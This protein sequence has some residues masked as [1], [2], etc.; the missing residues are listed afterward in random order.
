MFKAISIINKNNFYKGYNFLIY[1]LQKIPLLGKIIPNKAFKIS[2]FDSFINIISLIFNILYKLLT[3]TIFYVVMI[4]FIITETFNNFLVDA[5]KISESS[6]INSSSLYLYILV[7]VSLIGIMVYQVYFYENTLETYIYVKQMKLEAK[8]YYLG[9]FFYNSFIFIITFT[10]VN[11][12]ILKYFG[13]NFTIMEILSFIVFAY[14][15]R[16]LIAWIFLE[17]R[18]LD[19][20]KRN[21]LSYINWGLMAILVV[22]MILYVIFSK[23]IIDFRFLFNIKYLFIGL[24]IFGLSIVFLLRN[25][26][27]ELVSYNTLNLAELKSVDVKNINEKAYKMDEKKLEKGQADFSKYSGIEY[28][29]KIFFYRTSHIL[30]MKK[31][32][33]IAIRLIVFIA[34]IVASFVTKDQ[35]SAEDSKFMTNYLHIVLFCASYFIFSGDFFIRYCFMNMDLSMMKNNFYRDKEILL[36]SI[37]IRAIELLKYFIIPFL[38]YLVMTILLSY[39]FGLSIMLTLRNVCFAI[40]GL[41]VF[42]FHYLFAYYIIQP[43]TQGME[44]KNPLYTLLTYVIYMGG[45]ISI[46]SGVDTKILT[47]IFA[48]FSVVY[49]I[50]GYFGVIKLAPKRFKIK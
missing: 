37:K 12:F 9:S 16:F 26:S 13:Y 5:I 36:K 27:I 47:I 48:A 40:M 15:F 25:K 33:M 4:Y 2:G 28:I 38:A 19:K 10:P 44:V 30:K 49:M 45:Y 21:I 31:I 3:K 22:G 42:T 43:F 46:T 50:L 34:V 24:A 17:F 20:N 6:G 1:Y 35:L 29:N 41:F 11:Y 39:N 32:R 18:I 8:D 14:S 7:C 23:S